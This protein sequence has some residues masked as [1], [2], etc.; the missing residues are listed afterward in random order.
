MHLFSED[1]H[2]LQMSLVNTANFFE[3]LSE[4]DGSVAEF[5]GMKEYLTYVTVQDPAEIT[6]T[7]HH[8]QNNIPI[9]TRA[10]KLYLS[11]DR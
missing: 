9:W 6:P 2:C 5:V 3:P 4:Y 11:P 8:L 7:G 10:G 1:A